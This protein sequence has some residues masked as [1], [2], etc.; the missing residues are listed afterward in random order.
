MYNTKSY[1]SEVSD[2]INYLS[3]V[4]KQRNISIRA[5][6]AD[7]GVYPNA[8]QQWLNPNHNISVDCLVKLGNALGITF[9]T[10]NT[11]KYACS[12]DELIDLLTKA[13]TYCELS[14][15]ELAELTKLP[16]PSIC[17][18]LSHKIKPRLNSYL[19]LADA[20]GIELELYEVD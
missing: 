20:L 11:R 18:I 8:V 19:L 4:R 13:K 1:V 10:S 6:A 3:D 9:S 12:A 17:G 7:L 15:R 16:Q 14:T 2:I 5:L